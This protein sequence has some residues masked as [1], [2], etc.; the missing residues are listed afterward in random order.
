MSDMLKIDRRE[1]AEGWEDFPDGST[2]ARSYADDVKQRLFDT[3]HTAQWLQ[4]CPSRSLSRE[5]S[6][7]SLHINHHQP[8]QDILSMEP[9]HWLPDSYAMACG[10]CHLQF[11]PFRRLKHHCRMCG[12]IFCNSCCHKRLLLPPKYMHR[13]PQ[14]VCELCSS[15]LKPLQ[16]FLASTQAA[17]VQPPVR[18]SFD[19]VS[20][21]SWVNSPWSSTLEEDIFKVSNILQTFTRALRLSPEAGIPGVVLQGCRALVLLSTIKVGAGWSCSI[22]TGVVV[23]RNS[24]GQW[25]A[26]CAIACCGMGWGL[27]VGG[28]LTDVL[29]VLR[30]DDQLAACCAGARLGFGGNVGLAVG[31]AGRHADA[32]V[33][34]GPCG[35]T[36]PIFSYSCSKGAFIGAA[37]EGSILMIRTAVNEKFYG[38]S[39][40]AQQL[41][42]EP[43]IVPQ[44]PAASILYEALHTLGHKYEMRA[45]LTASQL[46]QYNL[47]ERRSPPPDSQVMV[48]IQAACREHRQA[49]LKQE[50]G[51]VAPGQLYTFEQH[52]GQT[53]LHQADGLL[54]ESIDASSFSGERFAVHSLNP[55]SGES[56]PEVTLK[57]KGMSSSY[58]AHEVDAAAAGE[59]VVEPGM[60]C[61]GG[62]SS[63]RTVPLR[64][65]QYRDPGAALLGPGSVEFLEDGDRDMM[66][67]ASPP[68]S[69]Y[70]FTPW[71][72]A[73]PA[74]SSPQTNQQQQLHPAAYMFPQYFS[75]TMPSA[76]LEDAADVARS[77]NPFKD[78][79]VVDYALGGTTN[80]KLST[81]APSGIRVRDVAPK[82]R[83]RLN[84]VRQLTQP[85]KAVQKEVQLMV[86][87]APSHV[88]CDE[89]ELPYG[90]L[91]D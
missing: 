26:P 67:T 32:A 19:P 35:S 75:Q 53:A 21:R 77:K 11:I 82:L 69:S 45:P 50:A 23:S 42:L 51:P 91:F 18:D 48:N 66:P 30:D 36:A 24:E 89:E 52:R 31:L 62:P 85:Q 22:G 27:Q 74:S 40:T 55:F 39:V 17:S 58:L 44:P 56:A 43:G 4:S 81:T 46:I 70:P 90:C 3:P 76:S 87:A 2:T 78:G 68:W 10:G 13:E 88:G 71:P 8:H 86:P 16:S 60:R 6:S 79:G 12:K 61:V 54:D 20:L 84:A 37:L 59:V 49:Q 1:Q 64:Q 41:L 72:A 5:S 15:M 25:S 80:T 38:Y 7:S 14:R 28:E 57:S 73:S 9:P 29:L 65:Q 63:P 47:P 33:L 34:V 83:P